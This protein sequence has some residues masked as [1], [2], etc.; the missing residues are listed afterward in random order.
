LVNMVFLRFCRDQG[1][2]LIIMKTNIPENARTFYSTEVAFQ[3]DRGLSCGSSRSYRGI[4]TDKRGFDGVPSHARSRAVPKT[5][6]RPVEILV[7][8]VGQDADAGTR[9]IRVGRQPS[10]LRFRSPAAKPW[11]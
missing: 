7:G 9:R 11:A 10:R 4:G 1:P 3:P 2:S 8:G 6:E 5:A